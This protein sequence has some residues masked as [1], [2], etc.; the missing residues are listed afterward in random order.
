VHPAAEA[1][2]LRTAQL[3]REET[4]LLDALVA[5]T[6]KG[7]QSVEVARLEELETA[8]AR[9][10]VVSLAEAAAGTYVPQAGDRVEEI[11]EL[12]RRGEGRLDLHVGGNVSAVIEDGTLKMVKL[13]PR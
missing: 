6:L 13:P 10:V 5:D 12:G 2:V 7:S 8:L 9:Q 3:L 1:N 4:E 11:L